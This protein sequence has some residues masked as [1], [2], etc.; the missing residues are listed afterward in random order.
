MRSD[1]AGAGNTGWWGRQQPTLMVL[2]RWRGE[3]TRQRMRP[4]ARSRFIRR[5]NTQPPVTHI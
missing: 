3:H 1:P 5:G 4:P 2:S